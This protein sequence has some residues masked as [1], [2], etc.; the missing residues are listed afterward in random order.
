MAK[1]WCQSVPANHNP[2][3]PCAGGCEF[4]TTWHPTHCCGRCQFT[5]GKEHGPRCQ[6][7][8]AADEKKVDDGST[9]EKAPITASMCPVQ[10]PEPLPPSFDLSFP[11]Q[12]EDGR[13]LVLQWNMSD[14]PSMVAEDFAKNH[15]I[16]DDELPTIVAFINQVHEKIWESSANKYTTETPA[17]G[18]SKDNRGTAPASGA[19][20]ESDAQIDEVQE[21][22]EQSTDKCTDAD[23]EFV[24][25]GVQQLLDMGF[26]QYASPEELQSLLV[27]C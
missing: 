27:D 12:V 23:K 1:K 16:P 7:K 2:G 17:I 4:V 15:G 11:V 10:E 26:A 20:S 25:A 3:K 18:H 22:F 5:Q 14:E 19:A 13:Q 24:D 8:K 9:Q 6:R 21:G